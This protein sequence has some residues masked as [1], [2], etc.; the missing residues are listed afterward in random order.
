M[1]RLNATGCE[2]VSYT[3][4]D[5]YKRQHVRRENNYDGER[6]HILATLQEYDNVGR[7]SKVWL[8]QVITSDYVT[9]SSFKNQIGNAY[10][11]DSRSFNQTVYENS[12]LNRVISQYGSGDDWINHPIS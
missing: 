3:H 12:P 11:G 5:V 7:E 8:P 9:P 6:D 4:L 1:D 2:A 10:N